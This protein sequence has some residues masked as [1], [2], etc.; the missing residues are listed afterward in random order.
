[1]AFKDRLNQLLVE[2]NMKQ[3][4]LCRASGLSS[5]QV[6]HLVSG[7]TKDPALHTA[8]KIADALDVSLD[9]LAE[10]SGPE[11]TPPLDDETRWLLNGFSRLNRDGRMVVLDTVEFQLSKN[12]KNVVAEQRQNPDAS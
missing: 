2:R 7:R 8:I 9:Y 11:P 6:T 5:A 3:A 10:N 4:D 12:S 1:M